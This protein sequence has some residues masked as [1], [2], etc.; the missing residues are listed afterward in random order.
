MTKEKENFKEWEYVQGIV[1]L[2]HETG[3]VKQSKSFLNS[4]IRDDEI[5]E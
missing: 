4:E 5:G 2:R 1:Y 3:S